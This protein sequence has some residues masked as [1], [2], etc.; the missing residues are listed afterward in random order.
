MPAAAVANGVVASG[1]PTAPAP[2]PAPATSTVAGAGPA[3]APPALPAAGASFPFLV[4]GGPSVGFG[5]G[6]ST[7]ASASRKASEPDL[8]AVAAAAAAR[9][10]A[11]ARRRR[12]AVLRDHGDE[13]ADMNVDV[14]PDW[15]APDDG[16]PVASQ[17][18]AGRFGF[19]GTVHRESS[20][21]AAGL[22]TLVEDDFGG[23]PKAPMLPST[24]DSDGV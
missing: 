3:S 11:R 16:E 15:G 22:S 17:A 23:G 12:R 18:R 1:A 6:M 19:A 14:D 7:S 13:F 8:A 20:A 9:E 5:S 24:W 4:G 21:T 10:Q 2:A